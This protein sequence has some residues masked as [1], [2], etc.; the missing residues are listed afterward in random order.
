M[1]EDNHVVVKGVDPD[2]PAELAGVIA[3]DRIMQI[4]G[5][6]TS[7]LSMFAIRERFRSRGRLPHIL[8][9]RGA[10]VLSL[11]LDFPGAPK[12]GALKRDVCWDGS[13]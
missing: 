6:D 12:A 1:R 11:S 8:I 10:R 7:D 4:D 3:D 9:R 2:S 13:N 5:I